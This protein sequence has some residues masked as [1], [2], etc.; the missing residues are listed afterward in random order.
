MNLE[1]ENKFAIVCASSKGL[2]FA[3]ANSLLNEGVKVLICSSKKTSLDEASS[4]LINNGFQNNFHTY[5]ADL[6]STEGV[7]GLFKFALSKTINIDILINNCGGPDPGDIEE[8]NESQLDEAI[9]KNLKSTF[10]LTKLVLPI[11][12]NNNW[13]R[14]INITSSSAKQPIDGLLLSNITRAAVTGFAKSI[15]NQYAKY[16]ILVNNV[17]PG[18]IITNRIIELAEK[19]AKETG[20]PIEMV[21]DSMGNDLPIG[22]LGKPDEFASMVTFLCSEKASYITGN[23][24]NIDGG[25][26]KSI[27]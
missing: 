4:Q 5:H 9:N 22:R 17:L 10:T 12:Q 26:I 19:K 6:S 23:S 1:I 24:I 2:G 16:N 21:L 7:V 27:F 11:M 18:R 15:S 25:L 14:I 13:G 3:I 8:L 20:K